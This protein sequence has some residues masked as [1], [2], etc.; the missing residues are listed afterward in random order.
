MQFFTHSAKLDLQVTDILLWLESSWKLRSVCCVQ[1]PGSSWFRP[2]DPTLPLRYPNRQLQVYFHC[3]LIL[4]TESPHDDSDFVIVKDRGE[5]K[6]SSS[7]QKNNIRILLYFILRVSGC[8]VKS[9]R[10]LRAVTH[11]KVCQQNNFNHVVS[12]VP[13]KPGLHGHRELEVELTIR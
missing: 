4:I 9:Q 13:L 8:E 2:E 10:N 11:L 7:N 6:F 5:C 1:T 12:V 3:R